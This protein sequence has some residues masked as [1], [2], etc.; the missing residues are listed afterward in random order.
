M[1]VSLEKKCLHIQMN[2]CQE[3][4]SDISSMMPWSVSFLF[5]A[6][7][8]NALQQNSPYNKP[9]TFWIP[10]RDSSVC[11]AQPFTCFCSD[12]EQTEMLSWRQTKTWNYCSQ[13]SHRN[14]YSRMQDSCIWS[15]IAL[16]NAVNFCMHS[17]PLLLIAPSPR[18][19]STIMKHEHQYTFEI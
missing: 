6:I 4:N 19:I 1:S 14:Y 11:T 13:K 2:V 17:F 8:L 9:K 10:E 15:N 18:Y 16:N 7:L 12:K 3:S 5:V